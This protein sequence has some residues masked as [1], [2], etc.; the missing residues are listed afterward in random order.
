[1]K[2]R[3]LIILFLSFGIF[4]SEI[5]AK[6]KT[7]KKELNL[8]FQDRVLTLNFEAQPELLQN[9]AQHFLEISGKRINLDLEG[10]LPQET[11]FLKIKTEFE[12]QI[13][14]QNLHTFFESASLIRKKEGNT[15]E[16]NLDPNEKIVFTGKPRD[17]YEIEEEKLV[18]L[19]NEALRSGQKNI[20]VP[21]KK[22]FSQV[23]VHPEL[24]KRGIKEI[25]AVGESNFTGSSKARKQNILAGANKFNGVIIKKSK[26]FSFNEILESVNES[27]GFVKELVIK[28]NK[29]TKELGGG[30][31]QVSTTAFRA[32]FSGGFPITQRKNHSYAVPYYKPFG[33]DSAIY[34]GSLDLRFNNDT[35]G[36]I[37]IQTFIEGEDLFFVFY[38]TK[39][40]RYVAFE[41]PF[42]SDYRKAPNA[43]EYETEDLPEG[44]MYQISG[45]HDGFR[46]EWVR[47]IKKDGK[48]N[49]E[50]FISTYKPWPA[51][52]LKGAHHK[53][54]G[55]F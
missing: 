38:G 20:R 42:I 45:A 41:G 24:V 7:V 23:V 49:K 50:S 4:V 11:D 30:V 3:F 44:E 22:N 27:D 2:Q 17:G 36:D 32:A 51:R 6:V 48:E 19:I 1:M 33:L 12:T 47:K 25:I 40:D 37:L 16:I 46:A 39:D 5:Q 21:A 26:R 18:E 29:T 10:I 14:P 55:S 52:V 8:I 15:V 9:K 31:C 28:G 43:I 53:T 54:N 34:L 35:E 13:S